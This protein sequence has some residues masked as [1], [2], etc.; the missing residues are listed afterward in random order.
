MHWGLN[1]VW[2]AKR[3][4]IVLVDIL[5]NLFDHLERER[6]RVIP[7]WF[8]Q[9]SISSYV[10]FYM[11]I[12]VLYKQRRIYKVKLF[13]PHGR[14]IRIPSPLEDFLKYECEMYLKQPLT[15]PQHKII[16]TY[17]TSNHRLPINI[18]R[19]STIPISRDERLCASFD[20]NAWLQMS[21]TL[22]WSV[23]STTPSDLGFLPSFL[24]VWYVCV[25]WTLTIFPHM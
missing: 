7:S 18:G 17:R 25:K 1:A 15:P 21:H 6:E 11:T 3:C 24:N 20:V 4:W 10:L 13:P 23:L 14:D 16:A 9:V 2:H 12:Y 5:C 19:W 22:C 8:Q